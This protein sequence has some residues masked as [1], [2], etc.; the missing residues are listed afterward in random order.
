MICL[1]LAG[2]DL[3]SHGVHRERRRQA[4][5]RNDVVRLQGQRFAVQPSLFLKF[6]D[7]LRPETQG[8]RA[9]HQIDDL[10][11]TSS[12]L[13]LARGDDHHALADAVADERGHLVLKRKEIRQ[14]AFECFVPK[15]CTG[16]RIHQLGRDT[17][18]LAARQHASG[19]HEP[20]R[21]VLRDL[22]HRHPFRPV[23]EGGRRRHDKGISNARQ[24]S[25]DARGQGIGDVRLLLVAGLI[26]EGQDQ[27]GKRCRRRIGA[28]CLMECRWPPDEADIGGKCHRRRHHRRRQ[29]QDLASFE[30]PLP[31]SLARRG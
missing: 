12:R 26:G 25:G 24:V 18:I 11:R 22:L 20:H 19:E 6:L 16:F 14:I 4:D 28:S 5:H 27:D 3:S 30:W 29:E 10:G 8:T 1:S 2:S 13:A 7:R 15:L 9:Q 21:G 31:P 23:C 17:H